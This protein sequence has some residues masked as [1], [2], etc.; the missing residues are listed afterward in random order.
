MKS[1]LHVMN[2]WWCKHFRC[3]TLPYWGFSK[4]CIIDVF[5]LYF[6]YQDEDNCSVQILFISQFMQSS[7]LFNFCLMIAH[8]HTVNHELPES[9]VLNSDFH[10]QFF[11]FYHGKIYNLH[12]T[13]SPECVLS[14]WYY[15]VQKWLSFSKFDCLFIC[16]HFY[17]HII[18]IIIHHHLQHFL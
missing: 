16:N 3:E 18:T 7:Y 5:F 4:T 8:T 1:V 12:V 10:H 9:W 15:L 2:C 6:L 14:F 17:H 13:S 11:H